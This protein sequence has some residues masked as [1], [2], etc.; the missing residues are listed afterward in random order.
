MMFHIIENDIARLDALFASS[1]RIAITTHTRPDG[2]ALGS[3]TALMVFLRSFYNVDTKVVMPNAISQNIAFILPSNADNLYLDFTNDPDEVKDWMNSSDLVV[4]LDFNSFSRTDG[5]QPLLEASKAP[6]V[7]VDHHLNPDEEAF[8]IVFSTPDISSASELLYEV[9][10]AMPQVN[11]D[12]TKLPKECSYALMS[13]MTTDTNNFANSVYPS[14][15]KMASDLLAAGVDRNDIVSHVYN[16]YRENRI[17]LIGYLLDRKLVTTSYGVAYT[18]LRREEQERFDLQEG[19]LE[20]FVNIPLQVADVKYSLYLREDNDFFR[21][22]VRSKAGYSANA[23][24]SR[25]FHGGGH[26][27]ASGGRLFFPQD[28]SSPS[29]AETYVEN[30]LKDYFDEDR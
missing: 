19:D 21:V 30:I 25:Y 28:I 17:R 27:Q 3:T 10:M 24:A 6:K 13:G 5:L 12:A 15:L 8:D 20:G 14:T 2:D 11:G 1:K 4:C 7:L 22:S 26:E 23:L 29:E 18:I 9:L 16:E